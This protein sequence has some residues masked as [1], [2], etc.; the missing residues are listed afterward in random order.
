MAETTVVNFRKEKCDINITRKPDN[1]I[2]NPPESGCF[3]NPFPVKIHGR[4][5]CIELYREYFLERVKK[6]SVFREAVLALKGKKLGCFCK[7]S[8]P[9]STDLSCHGDVIKEWLDNQP[10]PE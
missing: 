7:K 9:N 8:G 3:G 2:P 10:M 1:S 4:E 5:K 6:D